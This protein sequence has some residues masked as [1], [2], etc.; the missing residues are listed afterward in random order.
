MKQSLLFMLMILCSMVI[1]SQVPCGI[2][3]LTE[4]DDGSSID[5]SVLIDLTQLNDTYPFCYT[6]A[7]PSKY[8]TPTHYNSMDDANLGINVIDNPEAYKVYMTY[9]E[10][11]EFIYARAEPLESGLP[12]LVNVFCEVKGAEPPSVSVSNF[13]VLDED[14]NGFATFDLDVK[15]T[16]IAS[17]SNFLYTYVTFHETENDA[18]N[19]E[20]AIYGNYVN[21]VPNEQTIYVRAT[22][23]FHIGCFSVHEMKLIASNSLSINSFDGIGVLL[24]PNP[25]SDLVNLS[26]GRALSHET[27]IKVYDIQGKLV[28]DFKDELKHNTYKFNISSLKIGVYFVKVDNDTEEH[29]KRLCKK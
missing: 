24:Y 17:S 26:F 15:G 4:C 11:G 6:F 5:Q 19:D 7:D 28:L 21:T 20:N 18:L 9:G 27:K 25:A 12:V 3:S 8:K 2:T 1:N 16:E 14:D 29:I 13:E 22:P 10:E 23:D